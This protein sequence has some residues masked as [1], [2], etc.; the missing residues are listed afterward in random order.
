VAH[1]NFNCTGLFRLPKYP[2]FFGNRVVM[3]PEGFGKVRMY[4]AITG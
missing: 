1:S 3:P 2:Q 4:R